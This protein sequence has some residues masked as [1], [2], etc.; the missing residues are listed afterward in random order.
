MS[1]DSDSIL[2]WH[3]DNKCEFWWFLCVG[4]HTNVIIHEN[5]SV[6]YHQLELLCKLILPQN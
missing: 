4:G 1:L 3:Q 2:F 5:S 6:Y